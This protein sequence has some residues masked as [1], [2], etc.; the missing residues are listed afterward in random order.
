MRILCVAMAAVLCT[1][2]LWGQQPVVL[3]DDF[4]TGNTSAWSSVLP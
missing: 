1:V 3:Y 4:E 2:P